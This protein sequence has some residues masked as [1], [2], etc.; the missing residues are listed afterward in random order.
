LPLIAVALSAARE[1][2]TGIGG[3]A[4]LAFGGA[5]WTTTGGTR[6]AGRLQIEM[7]TAA[8][9]QMNQLTDAVLTLVS[10]SAAALAS[11]GFIAF[12]TAAIHAA[13]GILLADSSTALHM[14]LEYSIVHEDIASVVTGPG[15]TISE[16]DIGINGQ[17][18]EHMTLKKEA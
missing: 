10:S 14:I 16:I 9:A 1:A 8:V 7:W 11:S 2:P 5:Q 4:G 6:M 12:E 18:N 3:V 15:G 13:E 17:F